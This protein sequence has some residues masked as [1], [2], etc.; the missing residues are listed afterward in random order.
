MKVSC[1]RTL[2]T[3]TQC[4]SQQLSGCHC[5]PAAPPLLPVGN[6]MVPPANP[7]LTI[8]DVTG[9]QMK[10]D[11]VENENVAIKQVQPFDK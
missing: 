3:I 7:N 1:K 9:L 6:N 11:A 2:R 10:L 4:A 5:T 8:A